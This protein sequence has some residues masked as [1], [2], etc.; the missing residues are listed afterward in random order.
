[1]RRGWKANRSDNAAAE[2]I[3]TI[4]LVAA[5]VILAAMI[6]S[7]TFGLATGV[8]RTVAIAVSATQIGD[9]IVLTYEG[10]QDVPSLHTL[11]VTATA[12]DGAANSGS[13]A[14][15]PPSAGDTMTLPG[16]PGR[17]RVIVVAGLV[18]GS[19][20]VVLDVGV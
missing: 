16:T 1:M 8:T 5:A 14:R 2:V 19:K 12:E 4:V 10:G 9:E 6:S 3:G 11:E 13:F 7:F 15:T 18:D 17:D 20:Q